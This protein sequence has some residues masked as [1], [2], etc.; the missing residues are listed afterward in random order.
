MSFEIKN[1]INIKLLFKVKALYVEIIFIQKLV[2]I[3]VVI[4]YF[5]KS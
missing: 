1:I 5:N 4:L 2:I 3:K